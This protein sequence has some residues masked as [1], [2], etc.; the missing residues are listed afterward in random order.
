M[1]KVCNQCGNEYERIGQHWSKGSSCSHKKLTQHQREIITGILMGDGTIDRRGKNPYLRVVMIS[2]NYLQHL[3]DE[4][5]I[6]GCEIVLCRTA[7]EGAEQAIKSGAYVEAKKEDYSD[8]YK[9]QLVSHPELKEFSNW[10]SSGNK[11]WPEDIELTATVLKHWYCGDGFCD[12][13][14]NNRIEIAMSNEVEELE[15]VNKM[16][17]NVGLPAP[18]NYNIQERKDGTKDCDAQ[19]T[20][21]QSK[22]LLEYMG[23]PLPDF[24]Y[25][26]PESII[27]L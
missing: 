8:M 14:G 23:D 18:S 25:K 11:V 5:G 3:D 19:F 12:T 20:V 9:W 1:S 4:F 21:N 26:W 2:P 24:E 17:E 13:S 22:E 15:K 16:F 7:A 27:N 6:L 10:Y